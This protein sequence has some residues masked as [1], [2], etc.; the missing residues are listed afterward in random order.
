MRTHIMRCLIFSCVVLQYQ[1]EAIVADTSADF[2]NASGIHLHYLDRCS[3]HAQRS[4]LIHETYNDECW[5]S[6]STPFESTPGE[7]S[8]AR[9]IPIDTSFLV[10]G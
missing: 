7:T 1:K 6:V 2:F 8:N 9:M 10:R 3:F 4:A 5:S